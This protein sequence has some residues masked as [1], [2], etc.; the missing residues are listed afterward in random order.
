MGTMRAWKF[1]VSVDPLT[2]KIVTV[3]E[4]EDVRQSIYLLLETKKGERV[5]RAEYGSQIDRFTFEPVN[6]SLIGELRTDVMNTIRDAE[7]RAERLSVL[8]TQSGQEPGVLLVRIQ[9]EFQDIKEE[10]LYEFDANS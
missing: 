1:P 4:A 8:A 5:K 6:T 10:I 2:G 9:Y 3:S 7:P